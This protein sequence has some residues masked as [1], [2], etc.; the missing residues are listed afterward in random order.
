MRHWYKYTLE[1]NKKNIFEM[2]KNPTE[3][4]FDSSAFIWDNAVPDK[5]QLNLEGRLDFSISNILVN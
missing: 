5:S 2:F 3:D 1:K 4:E